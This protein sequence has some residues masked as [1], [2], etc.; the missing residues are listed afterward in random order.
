VAAAL[1]APDKFAGL[2]LD[3]L[4]RAFLVDQAALKDVGLL[5]VDVLLVGGSTAPGANR[6]SAVIRPVE[7]SNNSVLASQPA[8][9]VFCHS[10]LS[11]RTT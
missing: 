4:G 3:A 2:A 9:R 10:M 11:G 5:D 1:F 8:K 6:I 7:R